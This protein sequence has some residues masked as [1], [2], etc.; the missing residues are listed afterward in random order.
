VE[1]ERKHDHI[2]R[3][4][5]ADTPRVTVDDRFIAL[6]A[7]LA[8][9]SIP[10]AEPPR[11]GKTALRVRIA[12]VTASVALVS[13][14]A[15]YAAERYGGSEREPVGPTQTV[16]PASPSEP[17][18]PYENRVR[19]RVPHDSDGGR[20]HNH[21]PG[22][23]HTDQGGEGSHHDGVEG[24]TPEAPA[25]PGQSG[26]DP[27]APGESVPQ[28]NDP[29]G[30]AAPQDDP[31]QADDAGT[32]SDA[33]PDDPDTDMETGEA[34]EADA[35]DAGPDRGARRTP[36]DPRDSAPVQVGLGKHQPT[37]EGTRDVAHDCSS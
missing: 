33:D 32:E 11:I 15:A 34:E 18:G 2:V 20:A 14:G 27:V 9:A 5:R 26:Q 35:G 10:A 24:S 7:D 22:A 23:E 30:S 13:L 6:L 1:P 16:D 12:A 31:D 37:N 8:R 29:E 21:Y 19:D 36:D 28:G 25:P 17:A 4:L 3:Y